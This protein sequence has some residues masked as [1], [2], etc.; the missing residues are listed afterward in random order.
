MSKEKPV[1]A[2]LKALAER[3]LGCRLDDTD[4]ISEILRFLDIADR[5]PLLKR[6][7]SG[8]ITQQK[9]NE[10]LFRLALKPLIGRYQQHDPEFASPDLDDPNFNHL[11]YLRKIEDAVTV[12]QSVYH[13]VLPRVR[14]NAPVLV[15]GIF[16]DWERLKAIANAHLQSLTKRWTKRTV[17]KRKA[18][19]L[20]AWPGMNPMHRPDFDVIQ[21]KLEGP[22]HIDALMMPYINLEDLSSPKHLISLIESRTAQPPE[23]FAWSV[24]RPY[25]A[26]CTLKAVRPAA[27]FN[28]VTLLTGQKTKASYGRLRP[29]KDNAEVIDIIGTRF[30]FQFDHGL[31][32]LETQNKLYRFLLRCTELLLHDID[33]SRSAITM[34]F[35]QTQP[36]VQEITSAVSKEWR[37][38]S[39]MNAAASYSLPQPFSIVSLRRP[40]NA[41]R[42]EAEDSFWALHEDPAFFHEQLELYREQNLEPY[43]RGLQKKTPHNL[44][45]AE[46][47]ARDRAWRDVVRHA[48]RDII[49]WEMIIVQ[50]TELENLRAILGAEIPLSKR[51]PPEYEKSLERLI[52]LMVMI[53]G[54]A[55]KDIGHVLM[56]SSEFLALFEI[57]DNGVQSSFQ[58]SASRKDHWP[59]VLRLLDEISDLD[60]TT[61]M[62]AMNV[63]DEMERLMVTDTTQRAM[64]DAELAREIARRAALAQLMDAL[65]RHQPT[66][67]SGL[68]ENMAKMPLIKHTEPKSAFNYPFGKKRTFQHVE[69]M[70]LVESKLDTFWEQLDKAFLARTGENLQQW[71]GISLNARDLKRTEPWNPSE[72]R[73]P[74]KSN[75]PTVPTTYQF[76]TGITQ[77]P[78]GITTTATTEKFKT[79]GEKDPSRE[80][81]IKGPA[82][83][84]DVAKL[85]IQTFSLPARALKTMAAFYP[86]TNED[87]TSKKVVWKDFLN[88][89]FHLGFEIVKRHGSEW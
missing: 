63:L 70:R 9:L 60:K 39:D 61:M 37:S 21:R 13:K 78:V 86:I 42:D 57:E 5:E 54:V 79:R 41:K 58:L 4:A 80:P 15:S 36:P 59:P 66:P 33:L 26:A 83:S 40:A 47:H 14:R 72:E 32:I 89:M 31:T 8:G 28:E 10:D 45:R 29:L 7:R 16:G 38:V 64:I 73:L 30:G 85:A 19:L 44:Q 20:E 27:S 17:E 82:S 55:A 46:G 50:L 84:P 87:R 24:S 51:L 69:Q 22:S 81:P 12:E 65:L 25:E 49:I 77:D 18:L 35:Q 2:A 43:R 71:T 53:W 11:E 68:E 34:S 76:G 74:K 52:G 1:N 6:L 56:S 88:A 75:T 3:L 67:E 23:H 48:C 62:G